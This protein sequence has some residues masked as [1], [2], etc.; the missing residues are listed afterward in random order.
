MAGAALGDCVHRRAAC[1][2]GRSCRG[3]RRRCWCR[4]S[5]QR[6]GCRRRRGLPR[7]R[8]GTE[9]FSGARAATRSQRQ[10]QRRGPHSAQAIK[11]R[12]C[13]LL[14]GWCSPSAQCLRLDRDR[15]SATDKC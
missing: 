5:R 6:R 4:C 7:E 11:I 2:L 12:H 14:L 8:R 9:F 1:H 10:Q 3:C 13:P 15:C